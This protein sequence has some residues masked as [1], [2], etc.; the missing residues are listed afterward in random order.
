MRLQRRRGRVALG[1]S[2]AAALLAATALGGPLLWEPGLAEVST[3]D[4]WSPPPEAGSAASSDRSGPTTTWQNKT[5]NWCIDTICFFRFEEHRYHTKAQ[6]SASSWSFSNAQR[7]NLTGYYMNL[8]GGTF[9]G[10]V[11]AGDLGMERQC[12]SA[13]SASDYDERGM[14]N[15]LGYSEKHVRESQSKSEASCA[16]RGRVSLLAM[17]AAL[18][19]PVASWESDAA[20]EQRGQHSQRDHAASSSSSRTSDDYVGVQA[21]ESGKSQ[22]NSRDSASASSWNRTSAGSTLFLVNPR[23]ASTVDI[24][25]LRLGK[26]DEATWQEEA[27]DDASGSY[28]KYLGFAV[29]EED[30]GKA[31]RTRSAVAREWLHLVV[32]LQGGTVVGGMSY[33]K[34]ASSSSGKA[35]RN[36]QTSI[37]GVPFGTQGTSEEHQQARWRDAAFTLDAAR[38]VGTLRL[39]FVDRDEASQD[40]STD[41]VIIAG[42]PSG[43]AHEGASRTHKDALELALDAG[44][45]VLWLRAAYTNRTSSS[46]SQDDF[47]VDGE[48]VLGGRQDLRDDSRGV[49]VAAGSGAGAGASAG[50]ENFTRSESNTARAGGDDVAGVVDEDRGTR[51]GLDAAAPKGLL[52]LDVGY[53]EGRSF[54]GLSIAGERLGE[55]KKY[56]SLE[57]GA[58]GHAPD[59]AGAGLFTYS[60]RH[61]ETRSDATYLDA[62]RVRENVTKDEARFEVLHGLA[63]AQVRREFRTTQTSVGETEVL[64]GSILSAE[65][66]AHAGPASADAR[67]LALYG[68]LAETVGG[69]VVIASACANPGAPA[70]GLLDQALASAPEQART[71]VGDPRC[72]AAGAPLVFVSPCL[73][74]QLARATALGVA[75]GAVSG[76]GPAAG[77]AQQALATAGTATEGAYE[78]AVGC[79]LVPAEARNPQPALDALRAGSAAADAAAAP[80]FPAYDAARQKAYGPLDQ[81]MGLDTLGANPAGFPGPPPLPSAPGLPVGV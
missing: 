29:I 49:G 74:V 7:E 37:L 27:H 63:G 78:R 36:N 19:A 70:N 30:K 6:S 80:V 79:G 50:R 21:Q 10:R 68:E 44:Q 39:A 76:L 24:V 32:D 4:P 40:S 57:A 20:R 15:N 73:V 28:Q 72:R 41:D 33:D 77:A 45:G 18:Q 67:A 60:F 17:D 47:T 11:R 59:E 16:E 46:S 13:A 48:P 22:R 64:D 58:S 12:A 34:G 9:F 66:S 54:K 75:G 14:W 43:V 53:A 56:Q 69:A 35:S 51:T 81:A 25:G 55:D 71:L 1:A 26:G 8:L 42:V 31:G 52:A 61:T 3:V 23:D 5:E 38:G 2:A 65:A 62:F